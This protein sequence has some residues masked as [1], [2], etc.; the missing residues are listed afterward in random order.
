MMVN[1]AGSFNRK[2]GCTRMGITIQVGDRVEVER[3]RGDQGSVS[4]SRSSNRTGG[5]P[6][7]G[8]RTRIV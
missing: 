3:W 7:Y 6:A 1:V 5:F 2:I 4:T 8:S